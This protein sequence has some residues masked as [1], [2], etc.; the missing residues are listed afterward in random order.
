MNIDSAAFCQHEKQ[1]RDDRHEHGPDQAERREFSARLLAVIAANSELRERAAFKHIGLT[2]ATAEAL[3]KRGV[4]DLTAS[5][6]AELGIRAF[7]RAFGQWADPAGRQ[8]LTELTRQA[9]D[10]LRAATAALG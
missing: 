9:L 1:S 2:Q 10:E 7:D 6:A 8:T 3:E 4:P 5:L